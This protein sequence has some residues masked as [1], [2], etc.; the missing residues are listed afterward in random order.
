MFMSDNISGHGSKSKKVA[1]PFFK[2]ESFL[3]LAKRLRQFLKLDCPNFCDTL[4]ALY[5]RYQQTPFCNEELIYAKY[6]STERIFRFRPMSGDIV[7]HRHT[8]RTLLNVR[9]S[10]SA[11]QQRS[12]FSCGVFQAYYG[13]PCHFKAIWSYLKSQN[14]T[15]K[16]WRQIQI[17]PDFHENRRYFTSDVEIEKSA[18]WKK[19]QHLSAFR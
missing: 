18:P 8:E 11:D 17:L 15:S 6:F 14:R 1:R 3:L 13:H 7:G 2:L 12:N 4:W 16:F 5:F 19:F 9:F 10:E